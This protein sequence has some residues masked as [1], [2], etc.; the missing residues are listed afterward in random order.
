M[1]IRDR[2]KGP[3]NV[4]DGEQDALEALFTNK[5]NKGDV[6]VIRNEGPKGGPG[7]REMLQITSA[8]KGAGLGKDVML[9]TD[10]RF[11]G[12]TTGLCIGHISPESH[13]GGLISICENGDLII[14]DIN[15]RTLNIEIDP[16]EIEARKKRYV[17]PEPRYN[18]GA[19]YKYSKLVSGSDKGAVTG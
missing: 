13:D 10:G 12:G 11:S 14:L 2:F 18:S 9:I 5:I 7:M 4:F 6:V 1:C 17:E 8:I 19:L 3:A 15:Q 16:K